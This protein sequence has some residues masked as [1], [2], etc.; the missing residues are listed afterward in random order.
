M[1]FSPSLCSWPPCVVL[2]C[3]VP[4]VGS[5]CLPVGC[6]VALVLSAS[7]VCA[8]WGSLCLLLPLSLL[9]L[10]LVLCLLSWLLLLVLPRCCPLCLVLGGLLLCRWLLLWCLAL[11][12]SPCPARTVVSVSAVLRTPLVLW[13]VLC[14]WMRCS[15]GCR[16]VLGRLFASVLRSGTRLTRGLLVWKLFKGFLGWLRSGLSESVLLCFEGVGYVC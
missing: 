7:F 9:C 13:V 12:R 11:M 8:V 6:A 5:S 14:L 4:W 2:G 15:L 10:S 16:L 1:L 3:R